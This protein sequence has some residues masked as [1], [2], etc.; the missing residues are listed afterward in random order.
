MVPEHLKLLLASAGPFE[1]SY[2]SASLARLSDAVVTAFP[3]SSR[4][5]PSPADVQKCIGWVP[6]P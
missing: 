6:R 5:M 4:S 2:R 3:G 1:A